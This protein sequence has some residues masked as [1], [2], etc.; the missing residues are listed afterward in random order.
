MSNGRF[1]PQGIY[2]CIY[3]FFF[4]DLQDINMQE[5]CLM[6]PEQSLPSRFSGG[7][8]DGKC[9]AEMTE[10]RKSLMSDYQISPE[11]VVDC[12]IEIETLCKG[13]GAGGKTLHCL[14][15][16]AQRKPGENREHQLGDRCMRTVSVAFTES[17]C[18]LDLQQTGDQTYVRSP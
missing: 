12:Q 17:A 1:L 8:V 18:L 15:G 14:M 13:L 5:V 11:I 6:I 16:M 2:L 7:H 3:I 10:W 9:V 4:F